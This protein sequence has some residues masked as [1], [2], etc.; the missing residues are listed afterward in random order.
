MSVEQAQ[1]ELS[2][3]VAFQSSVQSM[4]QNVDEWETYDAM[5]EGTSG[6]S[7]QIELRKAWY[8]RDRNTIDANLVRFKD[9]ARLYSVALPEQLLF[10]DPTAGRRGYGEY[11]KSF[12]DVTRQFVLQPVNMV[13]GAL[14]RRLNEEQRMLAEEQNSSASTT[15]S[16]GVAGLRAHP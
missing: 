1:E 15:V 13:R 7:D 16:K 12:P 9:L 8:G 10:V 4:M 2:F 5:P 14:E 6:R 3:A 11:R